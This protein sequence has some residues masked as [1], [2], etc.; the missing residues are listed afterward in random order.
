VQEKVVRSN[1]KPEEGSKGSGS[2]S[3]NNSNHSEMT[4]WSF[5]GDKIKANF[6]KSFIGQVMCDR[7]RKERQESVSQ[8]DYCAQEKKVVR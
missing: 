4:K 1:S 7:K 2:S 5:S 8:E 3:S 6:K